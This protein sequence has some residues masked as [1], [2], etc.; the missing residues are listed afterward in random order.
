[1]S[2]QSHIEELERRHA[3]LERQLEDVV[4]HPSVDEVKIR[5]LKRRKLH[6]KDEISKLLSGVSVRTALH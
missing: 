5:D 2:L 6:L 1:M 3:A 4:H